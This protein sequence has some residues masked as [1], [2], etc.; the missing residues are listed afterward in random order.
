[1]TQQSSSDNFSEPFFRSGDFLDKYRIERLL[2]YGG[3]GEVYLALHTLL[4]RVCA[5]KV[6]PPSMAVRNPSH[7][8]RFL[9]EAK[10]AI[11]LKHPNMVEI[12]DVGEDAKSGVRYI[13]MEYVRGKTLAEWLEQSCFTEFDTLAI[14]EKVAAVLEV[15]EQLNIVHRDIK[16]SNIMLN[17]EGEVKVT[18]LGVAKSDFDQTADELALTSP[19][20]LLGTPYYAAP[21]QCRAAREATTQSDIYSLGATMYH[22]LTGVKPYSGENS[23]AVMAAV[24]EKD[25]VPVR[26]L[27][28]GV[29]VGTSRLIARMMD[30]R[31]DKRPAGAAELLRLLRALQR[32]F[33]ARNPMPV[34]LAFQSAAGALRKTAAGARRH[35]R[36]IVVVVLFL[37]VLAAGVE[38]ANRV[39]K[40]FGTP[41]HTPT[42]L[43]DDEKTKADDNG[44]DLLAVEAG[45][46]GLEMYQLPI[47]SERPLEWRLTSAR[48]R[49]ANLEKEQNQVGTGLALVINQRRIIF[50]KMQVLALTEQHVR[51]V[52]ALE[53]QQNRDL[54]ATKALVTATEAALHAAGGAE[55][56]WK[57]ACQKML[58]TAL[59]PGADLNFLLARLAQSATAEQNALRQFLG[60]N[61]AEPI[62]S[63]TLLELLLA[64]F[65]DVNLFPVQEIVNSLGNDGLLLSSILPYGLEDV[66]GPASRRYLWSAMQLATPAADQLCRDLILSNCLVNISDNETGQTPLHLAVR[67]NRLELAIL[68]VCAEAN[69]NAVDRSG[70]TPL[71][72][73]ISQRFLA[74]QALLQAAMAQ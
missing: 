12:W 60:I 20:A 56:A 23:F 70:Q 10:L 58:T 45:G 4:N 73:S 34:S 52:E 61:I 26:Q 13:V 50:R 31:P 33:W 35:W 57:P 3:M 30:K 74:M 14:A 9:R 24:L 42:E 47:P 2:G 25:P 16:P 67:Q 8:Q 66:D 72:L 36:K 49:L 22:M 38:V 71:Q 18:D 17:E 15:A 11:S 37:L 40:W 27:K 68:L 65:V 28:P 55:D 32:S 54:K 59:A 5:L 48:Q 39:R 53:A 69:V 43:V 62:F 41:K 7:S 51:H 44:E 6:L 63:G 1:M 29:S 21:E 64:R 46:N 19:D